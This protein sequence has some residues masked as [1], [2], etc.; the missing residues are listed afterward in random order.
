MPAIKL[1]SRPGFTIV[2]LLIVIVVIGILAAIVIVAYNGVQDRA[3]DSV[4]RN[5]LSNMA[6]KFQ[7]YK[8]DNGHFPL[9]ATELAEV[10]VTV[11]KSAYLQAPNTIY[12]VVP[13]ITTAG[14]DFA[15]AAISKSG[16][17]YYVGSQSGGVLEYNGASD[18]TASNGYAV[19]C[20][21]ILTG[22]S[23]P[24]PGPSPGY[25]SGWRVWLN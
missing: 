21:N 24:T 6:K 12:N 15:I 14:E 4:V 22:S 5:D 13:C 8:V 10:G 3:N 11:S 17:R 9:N 19:S 1:H 20:S 7:L 25:G 18:W 16:Q 2:E 23:L